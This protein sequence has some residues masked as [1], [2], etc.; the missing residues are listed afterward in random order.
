ME[1]IWVNMIQYIGQNVFNYGVGIAALVWAVKKM[2]GEKTVVISNVVEKK[3]NATKP[4]DK[5]VHN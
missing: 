4:L 5:F 3:V 2:K 1:I